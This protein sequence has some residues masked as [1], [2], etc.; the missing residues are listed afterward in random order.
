MNHDQARVAIQDFAELLSLR[1]TVVDDD[2][3]HGFVGLGLHA[4][5]RLNQEGRD[6]VGR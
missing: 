4:V 5:E 3:L 1:A 2:D 6:V